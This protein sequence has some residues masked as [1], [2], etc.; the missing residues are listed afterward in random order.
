M[1]ESILNRPHQKADRPTDR[2]PAVGVMT[3]IKVNP[4]VEAAGAAPAS[5]PRSNSDHRQSLSLEYNWSRNRNRSYPRPPGFY[6]VHS[7]YG[8]PVLPVLLDRQASLLG[9]ALFT[10]DHHISREVHPT[11]FFWHQMIPGLASV[12][13]YS[14][15][16]TRHQ[17]ARATWALC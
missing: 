13:S 8:R 9:I 7:V 11:E 17:T 14:T 16:V 3:T 10:G 6:R 5:S 4:L 15:V 1:R 12:E 2:E